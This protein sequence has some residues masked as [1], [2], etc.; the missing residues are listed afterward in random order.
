M[1]WHFAAVVATILAGMFTSGCGQPEPDRVMG[2]VTGNVT[3][4]DKPL[5]KGRV[6]FQSANGEPGVGELKED[7]TYELETGIGPNTVT[8]HSRDPNFTDEKTGLPM[9]GQSHVPEK[10]ET[11]TTSGLTHDVKEG[12]GNKADFV[13]TD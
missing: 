9:L 13:L 3:Y 5:S 8:V 6:V 1:R 7:G 12:D 11:G 10:Y 2:K 4:Q